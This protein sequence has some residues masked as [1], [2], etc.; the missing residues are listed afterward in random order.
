MQHAQH[1]E[2]VLPFVLLGDLLE[3]DMRSAAPAPSGVLEMIKGNALS[4]PPRVQAR[5][6]QRIFG[7]SLYAE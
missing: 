4:D 1:D 2:F 7:H 5:R 3:K 6:A